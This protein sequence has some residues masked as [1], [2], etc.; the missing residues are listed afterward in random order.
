VPAWNPTPEQLD[1]YA[2][3]HVAYEVRMLVAQFRALR[4]CG[5]RDDQN[6]QALLEAVL[7]HLR[8]LDEFLGQRPGTQYD[9]ARAMHW[10]KTWKPKGFLSRT[11]RDRVNAKVAHLTARR[12]ELGDWQPA[13][14]AP[15]VRDCCLR[16]KTFFADLDAA[17]TDAFRASADCVDDFLTKG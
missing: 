11:Q 9:D 8:L 6:R 4:R 1:G 10:V 5:N 12:T 15:L 7:V 16:L 13:E 2:S 3:R 14:L 17:R